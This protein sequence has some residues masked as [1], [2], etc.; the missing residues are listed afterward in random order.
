MLALGVLD[1]GRTS[2]MFTPD[3]AEPVRPGKDA[4][5]LKSTHR[6]RQTPEEA[7]AA[8]ILAGAEQARDRARSLVASIRSSTTLAALAQT[9]A[10][11]GERE[12]AVAAAQDALDLSLAQVAS[13]DGDARIADATSARLA[14]EVMIRF[15]HAAE[16]YERLRTVHLPRSLRLTSAVVAV[17]LGRLDDAWI[18]LDGLDGELIESFRGFLLAAQGRFRSAI[19]HLRSA[20][21]DEPNDAEAAMNLSISLLQIGATRKAIATA[22]RA[23][24]IAPGRRDLSLHYL[25]LLLGVG[26]VARATHEIRSLL[27]RNVV[28]DA[29]FLVIQAR[30][31]LERDEPARALPLLENA[32]REAE[33]EHNDALH[34]E[35]AANLAVLRYR[36]GRLPQSKAQSELKNLLRDHPEDDSVV[37]CLANT[38]SRSSDAP[39]LRQ[40]VAHISDTTAPVRQAFLAHQIAWLEGDNDRA[41]AAAEEWFSLEPG[42]PRAAAAAL[43]AVGIG[44]E[45]WHDAAAIADTALAKFPHDPS[46]INNGGYILAMAGRADKAISI[47]EPL[48]KEQFVARATLGLAHLANGEI[49]Q[50]MRLYREAAVDAERADTSWHSLMTVYQALIVRQLG[51]DTKEEPEIISA[52]A[53]A[54][55]PLPF[56]W[57]EQPEF[58]RLYG[59]C[60]RRDYRWPLTL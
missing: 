3:A 20:L 50:G 37:A 41:G 21:R 2:A 5:L 19:P 55:V 9:H 58:L 25:E 14:A 29:R 44:Q 35:V 46:I 30:A 7:V 6:R 10:V 15:G 17:E 11:L 13:T 12:D 1:E 39:M 42:N 51:L 18:S 48:A 40:A 31:A 34:V 8:A 32:L 47:L 49:E 54:P 16:V 4:P 56:D 33:S 22:L 43:V 36:M 38:V 23:S 24:R 59:V 28:P 60:K 57:E 52:L 27:E 26:D 53:L 45:R